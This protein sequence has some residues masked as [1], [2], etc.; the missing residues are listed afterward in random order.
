[1]L[2]GVLIYKRDS[3]HM[4]VVKTQASLH[5]WK[6]LAEQGQADA[7]YNLALIYR[8]GDGVP[9]NYETAVMW[10]ILAA[11]QGHANA[12]SNLTIMHAKGQGVPQY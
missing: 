8:D 10:Y 12:Q 6:P 9:Q 2:V 5:E 1:M 7:Q 4:K 11:K 3:R